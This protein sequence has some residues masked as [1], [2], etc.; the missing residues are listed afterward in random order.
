MLK[1]IFKYI[2][3]AGMVWFVIHSIYITADGLIN[4]QQNADLAVVLGNKVNEDGT[5]SPRLK[6]RLDETIKL[7]RKKQVKEILVSG[8]LGKEGYWEGSEMKKYLIENKIPSDKIITDNHG[9]TTEKTVINS[10]RIADS[11]KYKSIISVSQ[12]YHQTR[13]KKLFRKHHFNNITSSSPEYFEIRDLYS[14]FREFFAYY[15]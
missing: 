3:I 10:V 12:Y 11:L 1:N 7:Y 2:F 15:L 13:I 9:D 6:A 14:I 4:T 8:G 5:L